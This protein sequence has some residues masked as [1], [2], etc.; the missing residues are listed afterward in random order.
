MSERASGYS[1][2]LASLIC[3][4][5]ASGKSLRSICK[6]K[7]MPAASTVCLWLTQHP[8]FAEQ[9]ARAR[10]AQADTLAEE[11]LEIAD[12][13]SGDYDA[14]GNFNGEHVQRSRLRV[15]TRKWFASKVA[16]KKYGD[17][18][19]HEHSGNVGITIEIARY[20][21]IENPA[22]KQLEAPPVSEQIVDIP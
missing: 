18:L 2:L 21:Q 16:P 9:Y 17:K 4:Q 13:Q 11:T 19:D 5:I 8:D 6:P 22:P 14:D 7:K 15:D 10:E 12:D 3:D 20:A 1:Q